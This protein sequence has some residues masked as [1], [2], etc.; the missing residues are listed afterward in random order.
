MV[1]YSVT[2]RVAAVQPSHLE[3]DT[4]KAEV[5]GSSNPSRR[6]AL[7]PSQLWSQIEAAKRN[8]KPVRSCHLPYL[9][10]DLAAKGMRRL[11]GPAY[12]RSNLVSKS[13]L[14]GWEDLK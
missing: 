4:E 1:H 9:N 8:Q 7:L 2:P 13:I 14:L 11:P 3:G 6:P 12:G 5:P 10:L